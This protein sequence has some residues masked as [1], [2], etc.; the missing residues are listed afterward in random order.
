M[1]RRYHKEVN[2]T[3]TEFMNHWFRGFEK[4][5]SGLSEQERNCL[6]G[7]CGKAC[8]ES[9]SLSIY[10]SIRESATDIADFFGKLKDSIPEIKV[11]EVV[12]G[13][14]YEIC[15]RKCL[16]DLYTKGFLKNGVLC[17]CSRRSLLYNLENVFPEK[18]IEV[19]LLESILRGGDECILRISIE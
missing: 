5:L 4:G 6:L 19:L 2:V 13:K 1:Q 11:F 10:K 17:E 14:V 8:S 18:K 9:Y 12:E 15:Y 3:M 7:E 16:C